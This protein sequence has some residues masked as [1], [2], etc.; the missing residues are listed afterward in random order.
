MKIALG[1]CSSISAY[2]SV[3]IMREFQKKNV[4]VEVIMTKN[5]TKLIS[6]LT[7]QVL[8]RKKVYVEQFDEI[9]TEV[10][11]IKLS[12]EISL[13]VVAPATANIISKFASGIADDFLSTLFISV[14]CPV[15]IAP[16]MH[17]EM[18]N[19]PII[20]QNMEKL[21]LMGVHFVE[22]SF[23]YLASGDEGI[24]RLADPHCIVDKAMEI[25]NIKQSLKGKKIMVTAGPTQESIDPVRIITNRSSGKM[26]IFLAEEAEK[27]GA[28][29]KLILGPTLQKANIR[30][31]L[32]NVETTLDMEKEC[33]K[34]WNET[35]I[36]IMAAA[37]SD[38]RPTE[39]FRDKIKKENEKISLEF[40]RNPDIL[41]QMG[42]K[43]GDKI[44]I[45]F[46][47][48]SENKINNAKKKLMEKNLD[49]IVLNDITKK[50]IGFGSDFNEISIIHRNGRILKSGR[51]TKRE[52]ASLIIDEIEKI[53]K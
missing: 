40:L 4:E 52:I 22:P 17:S 9:E 12:K 24:G 47:A 53:I 19:N 33:L 48:E 3:E 45:G 18:Y 44:L 51:K 28:A 6:P 20:Q 16:A 25:L 43:K 34:H 31:E 21:K 42:E 41:K 36:G 2:K 27:R 29:V 30:G 49:F 7:F 1:V 13:L 39:Y 15:L 35:D 23:G 26:G 37:P 5:A 38:Y 50:G 14:K 11:H 10:A 8:S 46:A 32:I